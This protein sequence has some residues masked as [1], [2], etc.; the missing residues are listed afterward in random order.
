MKKILI[1][2]I[3]FNFISCSK[4]TPSGFWLNYETNLITE[5]QNDQGPFGGTLSINWI[6]DN[7]SEFKIKELTELTFEN[8]WKLIDSTEYKKAELTN[9][10]ES[11]KPNIN[12]PLKNFKPESKNSNTESKSFPRWIETDFTLYRFKTNWHIF[13]S[14]TDDSTNEN[15]FILLSSDNKKMTVYHLW[16]E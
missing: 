8:D 6:A 3:I 15:G 13:E 1:L 2:L 16:G 4:I 9:I 10:T 14:G 7:G 12:L 5:K 11:G